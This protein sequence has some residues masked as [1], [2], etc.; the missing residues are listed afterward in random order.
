MA[1]TGVFPVFKNVFKFGVGSL[2][3]DLKTVADL[4]SFSVSFSNGIETWTPMDTEGWQRGLMTAKSLKID[5]KG[6]RNVGD[7]GNDFIAGL[8]YKT[9]Q[10]TVVPFEWTMVSG[11]KLTFNCIVDVTSAEGGDSTNVGALEFTINSDG[12]PTYTEPTAA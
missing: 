1:Y 7:A 8:A 9:G 2:T 11:A 10:D 3:T 12:K 4:E 5:F 6:K